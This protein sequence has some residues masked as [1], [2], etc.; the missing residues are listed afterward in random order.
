GRKEESVVD[1]RGAGAGT[2][3][4]LK[5]QGKTVSGSLGTPVRV[6]TVAGGSCPCGG[7]HVNST[8]ALQGTKV[9]KVKPK[10]G[11]MRVSYTVTVP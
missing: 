6:V 4:S 10:K 8:L 7:T 5:E 9:T 1:E 3:S 11:T 2:V